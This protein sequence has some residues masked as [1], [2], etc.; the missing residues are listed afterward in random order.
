MTICEAAI[1][2]LEE[3]GMPLHV[4]E[5]TENIVSKKLWKPSGKTPVDSVSSTINDDIK[6]KGRNSLFVRDAP[7]TFGLRKRKSPKKVYSYGDSAE[8]VLERFG[9]KQPMHYREIT[10][11]AIEEGWLVSGSL[12]PESSM[13]AQILTEIDRCGRRGESPRFVKHGKGFV[14]LSKWMARGL[15]FEIESHNRKVRKE[16]HKRLLEMDWNEFERL[17]ARLLAKIGFD[18]IEITGKVKDGGIDVRGT[19]V[20]GDVI[21]TRMAVQVK[22]WK[23][24]NVQTPVVQQVRGSLGPHEQGLIITTGDFSKG[25]RENAAKPEFKPVALM[26]GEQLVALLVENGIG[27]ERQ[28]HD[29]IELHE[30]GLFNDV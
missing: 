22:R 8:K 30:D 18:E 7:A 24:E 27:V 17:I 13:Y 10:D 28:S 16:L 21:R 9:G 20:V 4:K 3:V 15:A 23:K 11:K 1:R 6:K 14:G 25:A 12:T 26:N 29:L 5:I 2:V 19:L